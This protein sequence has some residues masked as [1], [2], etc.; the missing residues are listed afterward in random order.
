MKKL[1]ELQSLILKF[2]KVRGP[3][4][5]E[6]LFKTFNSTMT[7]KAAPSSLRTRR[8]ELVALG[9]VRN[10]LTTKPSLSGRSSI[11]WESTPSW[12]DMSVTGDSLGALNFH[13]SVLSPFRFS[14]AENFIPK[15]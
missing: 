8:A 5:D 7:V 14:P 4:T 9:R 6:E 13:P 3:M 10:S 15:S 1:S 11:V 12:V 2:F